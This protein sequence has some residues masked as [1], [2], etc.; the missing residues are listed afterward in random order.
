MP[1]ANWKGVLKVAEVTCPVSLFTAASTSERIAFNILN[2]KTG[3]R[4]HR[5]YVDEETGKPVDT[6]DQVKGYETGVG[7]R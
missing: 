1:R 5:E 4:V 6:A 7:R 2:R 3:N